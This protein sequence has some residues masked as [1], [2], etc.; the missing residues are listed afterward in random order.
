MY[1][2]FSHI[3]DWWYGAGYYSYM[4]ADIIQ[5]DVFA[6]IKKMWMFNPK[7]GQK[8]LKTIIWQGTRE[9]ADELFKDFMGRKVSDE[10][11]LE[12]YGL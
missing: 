9:K 6:K 8:L 2:S 7:T 10:A 3:F 1:C 12:K 5:A 4:R 11:F